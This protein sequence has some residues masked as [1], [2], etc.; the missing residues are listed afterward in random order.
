M[1][2]ATIVG[3]VFMLI[4]F[5]FNVATLRIFRSHRHDQDQGRGGSR[6]NHVLETQRR[7]QKTLTVY[8]SVTFVG[9]LILTTLLVLLIACNLTTNFKILASHFY[10]HVEPFW[11]C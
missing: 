6:S 8:A 2:M 1:M 10:L 4:S 11:K 5:A 7:I 9:H 3:V